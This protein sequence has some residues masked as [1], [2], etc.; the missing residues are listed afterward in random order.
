MTFGAIDMDMT[1]ETRVMIEN[2]TGT[3]AVSINTVRI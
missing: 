2:A 1:V 3:I